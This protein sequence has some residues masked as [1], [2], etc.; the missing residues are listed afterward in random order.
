MY[1]PRSEVRPRQVDGGAGK[2]AS[3]LADNASSNFQKTEG[4]SQQGEG[5]SGSGGEINAIGNEGVDANQT[6]G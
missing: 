2:N 5:E 1:D 4:G 6:G 3:A